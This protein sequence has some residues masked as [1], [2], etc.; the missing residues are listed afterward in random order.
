MLQRANILDAH[1]GVGPQFY[2][3]YISGN[4]TQMQAAF[5]RQQL[6]PEAHGKMLLEGPPQSEVAESAATG[7]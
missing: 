4:P 7:S 5:V 1:L 3:D 2:P 6:V